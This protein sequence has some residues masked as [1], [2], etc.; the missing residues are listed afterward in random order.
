[1]SYHVFKGDIRQ[2]SSTIR[3]L[4]GR[5]FPKWP[6]D[7]YEWLYKNNPYG[8]ASC[9]IVRQ[10]KGNIV[11]GT[12]AVFPKK[13]TVEGKTVLGGITGDFGVDK[14]H[15]I[16][17][18]AIQLQKGAISTCKTKQ[19]D[20]LYGYPNRRSEAVQRR[21]GFKMLGSALRMVRILK[22]RDYFRRHIKPVGLAEAVSK[23]ADIVIR[24]TSREDLH[25]NKGDFRFNVVSEFGEE[26]DALWEKAASQFKIIGERTSQFL[27]WRLK[28]CPYKN[29]STFVMSSNG[30]K[31]I[32]GYIAYTVTDNN[33][34]IMDFFAV[35][36]DTLADVLLSEFVSFQRR[37]GINSISF[38]FF[39]TERVV[40]KFVKHRFSIRDDHRNI[41]AYIEPSSELSG[42]L[43]EKENWYLTETDLD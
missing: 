16:L 42:S 27:T 43:L 12:T 18:P 14:T 40:R 17:G 39:G 38:F 37:T 9:W 21:A 6:Q 8:E 11:V 5:K 13:V 30:S 1:M 23:V 7:K 28:Q 41:V 26:F 22:S 3:E 20:F 33:S 15:R 29:Y 2:D 10:G 32:L 4:W 19:F 35:D 31:E 34:H 36:M 25:M 24:I